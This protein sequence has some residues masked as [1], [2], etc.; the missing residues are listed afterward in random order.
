VKLRTLI[1]LLLF[2]TTPTSPD[3]VRA[4]QWM[5]TALNVSAAHETSSGV[6]VNVALID[7][8]VDADHVDLRGRIYGQQDVTGT[9]LRDS[10][11]HGSLMAGLI[12]G[13]GHGDG[14]A[15]GVLGIAPAS[16]IL[17]IK[18]AASSGSGA[19][20]MDRAVALAAVSGVRVICIAQSGPSDIPTLHEAVADA[21]RAD[22]V[23]VAA[24]GNRPEAEHV[25]FPAA[26]PGVIA[27]AGTDQH[28]NHAAISVTGPEVV[29]AAPAVDVVSTLNNGGY[30]TGDGTSASAAI[31]AGA[32]ALVR[33]RFP[34]LS[35]AE[36][37]HR[38]EATATD[39][40]PP[41]RDD[42]YGFGIVNLIGALT[43]NVPPL[44]P[45]ADLTP[46]PSPTS[47]GASAGHH[48]TTSPLIFVA[49]GVLLI[50]GLFLTLRIKK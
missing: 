35:A 31:I 18:T 50:G 46:S 45:D 42:E 5:L 6:G 27:A 1:A 24:V 36:V 29:L 37:V 40:G 12:A 44:S 41:G 48:H 47:V 19:L 20:A 34:H 43:A 22:I 33:S 49:I 15:M 25:N 11:G 10:T 38:L 8:G 7:T 28:G 39:K 2:I 16:R 9:G 4:D 30:G 13:E 26:Y 32:A 23:V 17:S 21:E 3:S 14:H